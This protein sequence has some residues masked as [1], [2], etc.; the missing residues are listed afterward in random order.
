MNLTTEVTN[1]PHESVVSTDRVATLSGSWACWLEQEDLQRLTGHPIFRAF[2]RGD[3]DLLTLRTLLVQHHHYSRHFTKYLC[4]LMSKLSRHEDVRRLMTNLVEEMGLDR[5][6]HITHS[7][8]YQR[9]LSAVGAAPHD[10]EPFEATRALVQSMTRYCHSEDSIEGL[11]ALCLGAEAIVPLIYRPVI[12]AL[13]TLGFGDDAKEFFVIHVGE[14][15]NHALTMLEILERLTANDALARQRAL[16]VGATMIQ[17]RIDLLDAVLNHVRSPRQQ[18]QYDGTRAS[19]L[20]GDR[21]ARA[22][23]TGGQYSS[24]DFWRVP[25]RLTPNIPARLSHRSIMSETSHGSERF[26]GQRRHKVH[27]VDLPS[28]TISMTIGRLAPREQTRLHRHNYETL[29][30]IV[31]GKGYSRI[32]DRIV[33]WAAGDGIYVPI[34]APHQHVSCTADEECVYLACENAPMLQNLG[35]IALREELAAVEPA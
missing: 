21:E 32:G 3:A 4:A 24:A 16:K 20:K 18:G 34:W 23:S 10:L 17:R 35:G 2:E 31:A 33:E 28:V 9:T 12:A 13:D 25:S 29:I 22:D 26:S 1:V 19:T 11:A 6:D 5:A 8:L 7:E 30:Y 15:E 27:I 14:D